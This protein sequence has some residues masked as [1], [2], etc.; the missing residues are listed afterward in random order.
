MTV[1]TCIIVIERL[2]GGMLECVNGSINIIDIERLN[3]NIVEC[4]NVPVNITV[5]ERL[6]I[7]G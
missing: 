7:I 2:N 1:N 4:I 5:I 3:G 6:S